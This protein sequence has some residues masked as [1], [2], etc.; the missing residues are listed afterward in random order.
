VARIL[1]S[2][3]VAVPL[4]ALTLLARRRWSAVRLASSVALLWSAKLVLTASAYAW[5][6]T[7][8]A[9]RY[10]PAENWA[11]SAAADR[12]P[13]PPP[14]ERAH[15]ATEGTMPLVD[16]PGVVE[17]AG[18]PVA[19]A[20]VVIEDPPPGLPPGAPREVQVVIAGARY[21]EAT[22]LG[23]TR[24]RLA[25]VNRDAV[26][27]TVRLA[28]GGRALWNIPLPPGAAARSMP[29][30]EAGEWELQ[31]ENH[32][33]ERATLLVVAHPY[34]ALTDGA[35]RFLLRGVPAGERRI[36]VV[37]HGH[38]SARRTIEVAGAIRGPQRQIEPVEIDIS[39]DP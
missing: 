29:A 6:A 16:V 19:G 27:H 8:S 14:R 2:Y 18:A 11:P 36:V 4:A 22:L 26:L 17:R 33:G 10:Q 30:P 3:L 20:V 32:P 7:G 1:I 25:L 39:E 5:L 15:P 28:R 31:C 24:D 37:R 13:P 38:P 35:G 12:T 21:A 23:S 34:A 9:S